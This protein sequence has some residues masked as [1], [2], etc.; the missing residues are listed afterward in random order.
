[1]ALR[2]R[3]GMWHY[4]FKLD[5]KEYSGTTNLADTARNETRARQLEAEHR[6]ALLEGRSPS[7][8]LIVREFE[9]AAVQFLDWAKT[10]Y[11]A[12]PNS[13]KRIATSFASARAFFEK[14]PVTMISEREIEAYK[15][16]RISEH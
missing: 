11:R 16:W 8:R 3:N 12:H 5:G 4:R 2:S 13:H 9:D 14:R 1:M 6:Q 7:R 15:V 10:E